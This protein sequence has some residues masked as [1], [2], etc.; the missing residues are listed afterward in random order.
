MDIT[1]TK[2]LVVEEND[3]AVKTRI[4]GMYGDHARYIWINKE[5][6]MDIHDG[7]TILT[8]LDSDKDYKLYSA[9]NRVVGT[10]K[11]KDL[12]DSHYDSVAAEVRKRYGEA[13]RKAAAMS[14]KQK[15]PVPKKR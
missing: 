4:P 14:A 11:G 12:Y 5:N 8:F 10:M 1:I 13:E 15:P 3:R 6:A 9:D 7:K 2:K